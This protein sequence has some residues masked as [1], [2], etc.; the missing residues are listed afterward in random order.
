MR[1]LPKFNTENEK[2]KDYSSVKF[3]QVNKKVVDL[4]LDSKKNKIDLSPP[5][6]FFVHAPVTRISVFFPPKMC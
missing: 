1:Q 3:V 2:P 5:Q 4:F 6:D